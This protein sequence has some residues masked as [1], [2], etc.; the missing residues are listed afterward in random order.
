MPPPV[1]TL[2]GMDQPGGTLVN[3]LFSSGTAP[4]AAA[5]TL[6]DAWQHNAQAYGD[7]VEQQRAD[8]VAKG[9]LDPVTGWPNQNALLDAAHQY[10]DAVLMGHSLRSG[11]QPLTA[12]DGDFATSRSKL[13]YN[14]PDKPPRPFAADYP[15][16][17]TADANG[18][19]T[20][21]IDGSPL[22]ARYV[23]GRKV[24]GGVDE[25]IPAEE[26][27]ALGKAAIG[28]RPAPVAPRE[29]SGDAGRFVKTANPDTGDAEYNIYI[30]RALSA[31][32][33]LAATG[34]EFGHM[35]DELVGQIPTTGLSR[36]LAQVYN[37]M[38]TGTERTRNLMG[39]QN[40]GYAPAE[41]PRE[42]MAEA[43]RAYL[44]NPNYLKTVAPRTAAAIRD[45]VNTNP[46]LSNVIQFN[47]AGGLAGGGAA[48]VAGGRQ[49]AD[50]MPDPQAPARQPFSLDP[51]LWI[52][53]PQ[54]RP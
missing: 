28:S 7:W 30:N 12:T 17:A 29:I 50:A 6:A 43:I 33:K 45:A 48:A 39:P 24:L 40:L 41:V 22:E 4:F 16:G 14:A 21:D 8:G 11:E 5:P 15:A 9:L 23:A 1:N 18:R 46:R 51:S 3:G 32:Q 2:A 37:T 10:A 13:M 54:P 44:T 47:S 36:E 27:D 20:T 31:G 35:V 53:P 52:E 19:L 38:G 25:A 26:Y 42:Q 34:H 49:P